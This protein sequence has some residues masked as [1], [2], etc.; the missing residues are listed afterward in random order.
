MDFILDPIDCFDITRDQ[1]H[2]I[3]ENT[4][5]KTTVFKIY[6]LRQILIKNLG[7]LKTHFTLN[8]MYVV[9]IPFEGKIIGRQLNRV[10]IRI[11][12]YFIKK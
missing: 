8:K 2:H 4:R 10:H 6:G 5:T 3:S 9:G 12:I 7:E 1:I 11:G